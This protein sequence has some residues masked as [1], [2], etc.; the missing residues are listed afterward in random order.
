[1]TWGIYAQTI[2]SARGLRAVQCEVLVSTCCCPSWLF[3]SAQQNLNSERKFTYVQTFSIRTH[4]DLPTKM[5]NF[6]VLAERKTELYT[7]HVH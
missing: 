4:A 7:A 6:S 2:F 1:M 5:Q 3:Q